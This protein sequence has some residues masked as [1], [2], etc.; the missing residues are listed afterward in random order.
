[1]TL[2]LRYSGGSRFWLVGPANLINAISAASGLPSRECVDDRRRVIEHDSEAVLVAACAAEGYE[3]RPTCALCEASACS[4]HDAISPVPV[5]EGA[6]TAADG[7]LFG[8]RA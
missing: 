8:R 6:F 7:P 2:S 1:M 3:V 4:V 5:P